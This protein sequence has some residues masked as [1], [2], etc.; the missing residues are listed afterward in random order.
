MIPSNPKGAKILRLPGLISKQE[1]AS[2]LQLSK[3]QQ[4]RE[5]FFNDEFL[6]DLGI[7]AE[8]YSRIQVFTFDQTSKIYARLQI[9]NLAA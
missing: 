2:H 4:L 5:K 7:S 3:T 1:L 9:L 6:A 8:M